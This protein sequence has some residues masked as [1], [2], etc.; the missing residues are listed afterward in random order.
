VREDEDVPRGSVGVVTGFKSDTKG[1]VRAQVQFPSGTFALLLS[2]LAPWTEAGGGGRMA[3]SAAPPA[4]DPYQVPQRPKALAPASSYASG[5]HVDNGDLMDVTFTGAGFG[6]SLGSASDGNLVVSGCKPPASDMGVEV[7][8]VLVRMLADGTSRS[9]RPGTAAADVGRILQTAGRPVVLTF[10]IPAT[11]RVM[12]ARAAARAQPP[13]QEERRH[14]PVPDGPTE[15]Q[16]RLLAA[17]AAPAQQNLPRP[18]SQI[19][20]FGRNDDD[21]EGFFNDAER[22]FLGQERRVQQQQQHQLQGGG[23]GGGLDRRPSSLSNSALRPPPPSSW[24]QA[25]G[26]GAD[27]LTAADRAEQA[28]QAALVTEWLVSAGLGH[29]KRGFEEFGIGKLEDLADPDL[30]QEADL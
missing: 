17:R 24:G 21:D 2:Q 7:G 23:S 15:L 4:H 26:G 9:V 25:G 8:F 12:Q 5:M 29:L 18:A 13:Q 10:R 6:V 14:A 27:G 1:R 30:L 19:G 22:N 28:E 3:A 20:A 16:Q 11:H